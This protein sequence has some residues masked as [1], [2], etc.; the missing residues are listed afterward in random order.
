MKDDLIA[1]INAAL[2]TLELTPPAPVKIDRTKDESHG[3]FAC[4]VAL[5]LAKVAGKPPRQIA[6]ELVAALPESGL[7]AKT[8][9]AG[10]GFINFFLNKGVQAQVVNAVL[11]QLGDYGRSQMGS[12]QRVQVEYVSANPTG[13]LHVGHGRGAAY[14][15]SLSNV[16]SF[17]GFDVHREYYVNDA[18]RQMDIL[19]TSSWLR[20]L[21]LCG[22]EFTFPV[23]GYKGT[24]V[25]GDI[26][27]PLFEQH[28]DAL[29][30]S[31]EEIFAGVP[32]DEVKEGDKVVSGDKEAHIDG[33]INNAKAL[34]G[35]DYEI[36][37]NAALNTVLDDIKDDLA[38][39]GVEYDEW[40]SERSLTSSGMV[41]KAV[42]TLQ[43]A[44]HIY[45]DGG[46][47]WF[48]STAFGD[49][50][51]RVVVRDNGQ[52]TYFASDIAYHL[53]KLERGFD[54]I[55]DIWGAD[56]HGYVPRVK[57]SIEALGEDASRLE[58][59]L[60]QFA[61]LYRG[62][63]KVQ[64]S[65]RSGSFVT[66]RELRDEVGNDATRFFYAMRGSDQHLDFDMKLAV[67]KSKD[68]PVYYAQYAHAR[69]HSIMRELDKRDLA[70][71]EAEGL[72]NLA[73]LDGPKDAALLSELSRFPEKVEL[74][75]KNRAPHH[76]AH[77]L[78]DLCRAFH[79]WYDDK[80]NKVLLGDDEKALRNARLVL[81]KSAAQVVK[82][83]LTLLGVSAPES[84]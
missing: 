8:E 70:F 23:N 25:S 77:Y 66:L 26:A 21:E 13:P 31:A 63:E 73:L 14:G 29:K 57:A 50:K 80:N 39:F 10:P 6:E 53:N 16:L 3:D 62:E 76:I 7:I 43:D 12:G 24:Y 59:Q 17:A 36:P 33:L 83:G 68:N 46:A 5:T 19:A 52:A 47:L 65:T 34:L 72:A 71:D 42:K 78:R 1:L 44:G 38:G 37:F 67:E 11:E 64:M 9:I 49:E 48:K 84:M 35:D 79:G 40:F 32:A 2:A 58:V 82:N 30:R 20:Y 28:G 75:A 69:T 4:N 55:I 41:D 18:G 54:T 51:D 15:A 61:V 81:V 60:V 56:H 27:Q 22:V 45:E 74:A